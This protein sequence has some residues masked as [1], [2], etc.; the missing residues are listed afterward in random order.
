MSEAEQTYRRGFFAALGAFLIWGLLPF[1]IH[2]LAPTPSV[3][4]MAH[5][6]IWACVFVFTWLAIKGE[7]H[8]VRAALADRRTAGLLAVTATLV[9]VN[10]LIYVWAVSN[11]HVIES[12]LGYFINPL[13]SVLM[14]VFIL[15]ERLNATQWF[16]VAL[17]A[18]G[19][20]W[21]TLQHGAPPWIALVLALT[22]GSYGLLRKQVA[23]DSVAGLGV[24]TLLIAPVMLV[25]LGFTLHAGTFAWGQHGT[26]VDTLLV[27]S[28]AVTAVPLVLFA[29]GVRRIPL[30]TVGILQYLGPS[31][32]FLTGLYF[33]HEPFTA[34]QAVGFALIWAALFVYAGE[35]LWRNRRARQA[36]ALMPRSA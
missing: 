32:Q 26:A 28:G 5:R 7:L 31:L 9:S 17:A 1:Y 20:L 24:E 25:Y 34:V 33:F 2:L 29:Y 8:K 14:G 11:G 35:G 12:S 4:I 3:Q 30:S 6:V 18:G 15:K 19:V 23:V 27:L 21:L 16:A 13:V 10:W 22:F 36:A